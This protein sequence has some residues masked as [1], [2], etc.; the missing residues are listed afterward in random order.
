MRLRDIRMVV[1]ACSCGPVTGGP[2]ETTD[3][4]SETPPDDPCEAAVDATAFAQT[5]LALNGGAP[6]AD[7]LEMD[8]EG[9]DAIGRLMVH[10]GEV[11]AAVCVAT[12]ISPLWAITAAHCIPSEGSLAV[13]F[14]DGARAEVHESVIHPVLDLALLRF[15]S[16]APP[17]IPI[18]TPDI[19]QMKLDRAMV[20]GFERVGRTCPRRSFLVGEIQDVREDTIDVVSHASAG[21]CSGDSGS[22][23]LLRDERGN[24]GVAAIL[25]QGSAT[26][27]GLDRFVRANAALDW[28]SAVSGVS[29][30]LRTNCGTLDEPGRCFGQLAVWC[31]GETV[32]SALCDGDDECGWSVETNGYRC[33]HDPSCSGDASGQCIDGDAVHCD[34][35]TAHRQ[36]CSTGSCIIAPDSGRASCE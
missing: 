35:G 1:M 25:S 9:A 36:T 30:T 15:A 14:G 7:Y 13:V 18:I 19:G 26:C 12:A 28:F 17:E 10:S 34:D 6:T 2:M 22:P 20:G 5:R 23:L 3:G 29:S 24:V 16:D 4:G 21:A 32:A 33:T 8:A 27:R 11:Q 31:N